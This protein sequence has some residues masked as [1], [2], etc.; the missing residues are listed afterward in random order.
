MDTGRA[1]GIL[2][3][4]KEKKR[5]AKQSRLRAEGRK[6]YSVGTG[7]RQTFSS[8]LIGSDLPSIGLCCEFAIGMLHF[9][10]IIKKEPQGAISQ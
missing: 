6:T 3:G 2:R 1:V 7:N 8:P 4:R 10:H 9:P 5:V